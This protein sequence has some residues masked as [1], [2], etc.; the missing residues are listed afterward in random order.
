MFQAFN[1]IIIEKNWSNL[2]NC[3]SYGYDS[4]LYSFVDII[5]YE[6]IG[7]A[8]IINDMR[9]ARNL[10]HIATKD[11]RESLEKYLK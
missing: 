3:H 9:V 11:I 6:I 4:N 8:E 5:P 10:P 2:F 7:G 1:N